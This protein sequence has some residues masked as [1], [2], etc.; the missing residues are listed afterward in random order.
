MIMSE[1]IKNLISA[2]ATGNAV[3]TESA[4]NSAMAEKIST[5]LDTMRQEVA[6]GM[7]KQQEAQTEVETPAATE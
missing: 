5:R 3:D 2:I 7:F 4:F 6:Q 1:T